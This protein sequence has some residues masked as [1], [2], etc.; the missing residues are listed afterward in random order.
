MRVSLPTFRRHVGHAVADAL[1]FAERLA[2]WCGVVLPCVHVP[3]L[4]FG[5]LTRTTAP[6]LAVLW[7]LHGLSLL[8]GARYARDTTDGAEASADG[9][10]DRGY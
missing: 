10:T 1:A 6:V 8:A 2:F 3:L 7:A 9:A 4:V 5:G